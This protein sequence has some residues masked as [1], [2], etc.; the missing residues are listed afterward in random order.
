MPLI[1]FKTNFTNLK[2]GA[3]RPGGGDSGQ[4]YIQFPIP[5]PTTPTNVLD[6]YI[7]N[8][9]S[10]DYPVRGGS[11]KEAPNGAY[12]TSAAIF[13]SVLIQK[14][15]SSIPRGDAFV[16]KQKGLQLTNP[17]TQVSNVV[18]LN[19]IS[20]LN[21]NQAI[22]PVT[23][24]YNPLNTIAQAGVM[25]TGAFFNRQ[26]LNPTIYEDV[27]QTY[28]YI[29]GAPENNQPGTNRLSILRALKLLI[30]NSFITSTNSIDAYGIDPNLVD[31]LGISPIQGQLF[32]YQGGPG[33]V[34]G[35]G[36]TIINRAT[37]TDAASI[38][39][40]DVVGFTVGGVQQAYSAIG[41][42][43]AQLAQQ[44]TTTGVSPVQATIQDFRAQTNNGQPI[45][46][47]SSYSVNTGRNIASRINNNIGIGNPGAPKLGISYNNSINNKGI[48]AVNALSPFYYDSTTT[49]P[50]TEGGSD[51]KDIIKFAFECIDNDNPANTVGLVFRAFLEGQIQDSNNA[52]YNSFK[53]LGRGETFRTYQGFERSISFSFK[54][55]AQSRQEMIPLYKKV[56]QLISQVYPDY[57]PTY[58]LMRGNV[59]NLT[60]GDYIYRMPGF[61]DN[62][63]V[64]I[65]N[66]NTPWEILLK[67][68]NDA[69]VRQLP[70]MITIQ[71][72]FKPIMNILPRK[73]SYSNPF[74]PLIANKD[75]FIDAAATN[76][77]QRSIPSANP[78][79]LKNISSAAKRTD[80]TAPLKS[81]TT[82]K[83][84]RSTTLSTFQ[85]NKLSK[86]SKAEAQ[87]YLTSDAIYKGQ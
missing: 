30:N 57:S 17:L 24:T 14:F 70:H 4:P 59:V 69:D 7:T 87:L 22:L 11:L 15:I 85:L 43:Y 34:Y 74:V 83:P 55:F 72:S 37:D 18:N 39:S 77:I 80:Y 63:N 36:S 41:F 13:D 53:Y 21:V 25:G 35:I 51:T 65:D 68:F 32:N 8:R 64:T 45:I 58:N 71:C 48:D 60:I 82:D 67:Q 5:G 20:F 78:A 16:N 40:N 26:G 86:M 23:R 52:S 1:N 66:S 10:L 73:Q 46:P 29:A 49:D 61:L 3:D 79:V 2:Y 81:N 50:W 27:Q 31:R 75:H 33:S 38:P 54:V 42:S 44:N 76:E 62:V 56:N 47:Y 84:L 28:E 19:G 9:N 6:Y 12:T